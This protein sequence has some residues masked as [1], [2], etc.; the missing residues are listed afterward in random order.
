VWTYEF[1]ETRVEAAKEEFEQNGISDYVTVTHR[2][3]ERDGFPEEMAGRADA[4]F[5]DLPGPYKCVESVA[6]SLRP[7]GVFCSF[8]PCIEQVQKTILEMQKHGFAD[9]KTVELLGREYDVE[10]KRLQ[11]DLSAP[12]SK[13]TKVGWRKDA[14]RPRDAPAEDDDGTVK[15]HIITFPRQR[16][17]SHTAYLT[18]A[19]L[20][21]E[22]EGWAAT[23]AERSK[24]GVSEDLLKRAAEVLERNRRSSRDGPTSRAQQA[25]NKNMLDNPDEYSE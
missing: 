19:R 24:N 8:S 7:D 1:N 20:V 6:R 11:R 9:V 22:P 5:L 23:R 10:G 21:P 17:Q 18:F 14:K 16:L 13:A 2:D 15:Q 25:S 3:I 4:V 12:L